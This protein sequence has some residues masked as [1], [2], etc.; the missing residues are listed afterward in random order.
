MKYY[1][2]YDKEA[3]SGKKMED[4][5]KI[6]K[7]FNVLYRPVRKPDGRLKNKR[8][9]AYSSGGMGTKIRDAE[10]GQHYNY[11]VGSRDEDLFFTVN[12]ATGECRHSNTLFYLSPQ[13]YMAHMSISIVD[14]ELIAAWEE[15]RNTRL[16]ERNVQ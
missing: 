3:S 1:E 10:S 7:G 4:I 16:R 6:D 9:V 14:E 15:K 2:D 11:I 13:Q 8:I 12:L 5:E